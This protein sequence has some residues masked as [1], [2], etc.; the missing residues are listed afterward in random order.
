MLLAIQGM[1][2]DVFSELER[3]L[4]KPG[5]F[6]PGQVVSE[7]EALKEQGK[8]MEKAVKIALEELER[9]KAKVLEIRAENADLALESMAGQGFFVASNDRA[10]RKRIKG[11]GGK[12]IYLRQGRFLK[13]G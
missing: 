8:G 10:L 3:M 4:G 7:L 5:F 6:V 12:V 11:F 2:I 9:H 1:K 13:I